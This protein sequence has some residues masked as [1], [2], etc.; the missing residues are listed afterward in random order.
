M[1]PDRSA[2]PHA[3]VLLCAGSHPERAAE[4]ARSTA[5]LLAPARALVLS[6]RRAPDRY[7]P[8]EAVFEAWYGPPGEVEAE[9]ERV[10]VE[11][12][13]AACAVLAEAGWDARPLTLRDTHRPWEVALE[14]AEI[15]DAAIV[16]AGAGDAGHPGSLGAEVRALAHRS[17]RPLLV[18]PA[19]APE[20]DAGA[21]ALFA[22]DASE[23]ARAAVAAADLLLRPRPAVIATVWHS[24]L[25][26]APASLVGMPSGVAWAGAE[27]L[28]ADARHVAELTAEDGAALLDP[29]RWP[30]TERPIETLRGTWQPLVEAADDADAAVVVTG[31]RGR[32]RVAAALLGSTAEG[33]LRHAGRPVLLVPARQR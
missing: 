9:A 26:A 5:G 20:A 29:D 25:A 6:V 7:G 18:V 12:T 30:V 3:P 10:A 28:D 27:K 23:P 21:P 2:L 24:V 13:E 4:L 17:R 15:E 19:D 32:S 14:L 1:Q 16:V 11:A 33:L 22:F 31:T 8:V